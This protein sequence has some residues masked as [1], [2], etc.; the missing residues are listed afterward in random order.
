MDL[1]T[2]SR[3]QLNEL[4]TQVRYLLITMRKAKLHTEPVAEL[5]R[6]L[7]RQLGE[8]RRASFDSTNSDYKGY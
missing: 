4:E 2:I 1:D 6:D 7:E 5:L 8:A 3:K